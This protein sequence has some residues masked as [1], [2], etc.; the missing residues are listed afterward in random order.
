MSAFMVSQDHIDAM[1][2]CAVWGPRNRGGRRYAG[3]SMST[4]RWWTVDPTALRR[5]PLT[6]LGGV[7][8]EARP[9]TADAV[10][11][12][13][14]RENLASIQYRYPDT[15]RGGAVPGPIEP[16]WEHD[17]VFQR[18]HPA[19]AE[20]EGLKLIDCYEYQACEHPGW[21]ASEAK[22]FCDALRV[23]LI[24]CLDGYDEARGWP[25]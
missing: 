14:I 21:P 20:V 6:Q 23:R 17:Y 11:S 22:S 19:P 3:A 12:M 7:R 8:R 24:G 18:V 4:L 15:R 16:Y 25:W 1:V 5:L 9:D 2:E 10:G 13:L